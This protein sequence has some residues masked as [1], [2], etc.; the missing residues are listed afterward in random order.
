MTVIS[1]TKKTGEETT[2]NVRVEGLAS[3]D[4]IK[5]VEKTLGLPLSYQPNT[6]P[7]FDT[8]KFDF[9]K[10][11]SGVVAAKPIGIDVKI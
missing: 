6:P 11:T 3:A 5:L 1:I 9:N 10:F 7:F 2:M 4:I 8:T